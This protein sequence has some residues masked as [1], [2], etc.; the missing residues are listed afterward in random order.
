[1]TRFKLDGLLQFTEQLVDLL[2]LELSALERSLQAARAGYEALKREQTA[3]LEG[4]ARAQLEVLPTAFAY[5]DRLK[6][7]AEE[8]SRAIADLEGQLA[9]KR[10]ELLAAEKEHKM[11]LKL[12]EEFEATM[13][14]GLRRREQQFLDDVGSSRHWRRRYGGGRAVS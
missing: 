9:Q 13:L 1:M 7:R 10:E 3:A 14:A 11:L 4:L 5:L 2:T 8:L 12:K 6:A